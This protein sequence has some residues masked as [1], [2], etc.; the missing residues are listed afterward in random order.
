MLL[1][2]PIVMEPRRV[3]KALRIVW[4]AMLFSLFMYAFVLTRIHAS[5]N[6]PP[7]RRFQASITLMGIVTGA[8]VLYLR[9][10][11]IAALYSPIEPIDD[12]TLAR[13]IWASHVFCYVFSET[14]ALFGFVL[15]FMRGGPNFYVPLY[16]GGVLLMVLCFPRLPEKE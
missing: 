12:K 11:R 1:N 15:A 6:I 14:T 8:V 16:L 10:V 13:K 4:A 9:F 7:D 2:Q 5:S 3:L